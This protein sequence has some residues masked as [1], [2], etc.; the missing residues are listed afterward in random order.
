[1]LLSNVFDVGPPLTDRLQWS[2]ILVERGADALDQF[3]AIRALDISQRRHAGPFGNVVSAS[4]RAT[5]ILLRTVAEEMDRV[6]S[7]RFSGMN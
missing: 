4:V 1:L 6:C 2:V 7:T 5:R 3:V